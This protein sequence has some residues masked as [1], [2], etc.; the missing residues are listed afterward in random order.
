MDAARERKTG[1]KEPAP[2]VVP[3]DFLFA[4]CREL[5][6]VNTAFARDEGGAD[7]ALRR[8]SGI[9]MFLIIRERAGHSREA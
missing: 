8:A 5:V 2:P 1:A 6:G 3:D 9:P 4:G 7:S